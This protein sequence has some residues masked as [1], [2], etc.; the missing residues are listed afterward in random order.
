MSHQAPLEG[1]TCKSCWDDLSAETYVEYRAEEGGAWL[2]SGYCQGCVLHLQATQWG[3]YTSA[4]AKTTCKAEQNRLLARGPPINLRDS[5][6]QAMPC[7]D[8]GEV[9][10]L[11]FMSDGQER[12]A[13]LVGSLVGEERQRYWDEQKAFTFDEPAERGEGA[14]AT[15]DAG[16]TG[17]TTETV[18]QGTDGT[19]P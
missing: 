10:S 2:A 1:S 13:K 5:S 15:A 16:A 6:D 14:D 8:S 19:R 7:P 11:W 18:F 17:A 4:L 3:T 12:S 9:I